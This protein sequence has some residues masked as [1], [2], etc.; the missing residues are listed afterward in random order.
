MG[1]E[2]ILVFLRRSGRRL[3]LAA[4][5]P[6]EEER[7]EQRGDEGGGQ[8]AAKDAGTHRLAGASTGAAA[9]GRAG[10]SRGI[11]R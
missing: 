6:F 11:S 8:H 2:Y 10:M 5:Q 4:L 1:R 3:L 9:Q 7:D